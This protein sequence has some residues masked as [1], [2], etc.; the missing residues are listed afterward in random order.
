MENAPEGHNFDCSEMFSDSSI[1]DEFA[2]VSKSRQYAAVVQS[3]GN[4]VLYK[5]PENKALWSSKTYGKGAAPFTLRLQNDGNLV[6]Y[7]GRK[8]ATWSSGT[9][10]KGKP[11][12]KLIMQDDGDLLLRDGN[13][14][15]FW[16]TWTKQN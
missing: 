9:M 7:D 14:Q 11:P 1:P 13:N 12:Y 15:L 6:L 10:G 2:L 3:D 16:G 4:L 5:Y 8:I